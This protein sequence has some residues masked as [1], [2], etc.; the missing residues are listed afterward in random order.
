MPPTILKITRY[1]AKGEVFESKQELKKFAL[2][3][4]FA[5]EIRHFSDEE[6]TFQF[7]DTRPLDS[8][9]KRAGVGKTEREAAEDYC[10]LI[11]GRRLVRN[12]FGQGSERFEVTC[13]QLIVCDFKEGDK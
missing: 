12:E 5:I 3:N 4:N 10:Q 13:P 9:A 2:A 1:D 11:S 6:I 8:T 7:K